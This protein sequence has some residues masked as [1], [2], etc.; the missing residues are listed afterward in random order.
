LSFPKRDIHTYGQKESQ[1]I[2]INYIES[3][4]RGTIIRKRRKRRTVNRRRRKR[5]TV[6]RMRR[7]RRTIIRKRRK[8]RERIGTNCI[9]SG[10]KN[11]W[12]TFAVRN[13][14]YF[15]GKISYKGNKE[16]KIRAYKL[17]TTGFI[18]LCI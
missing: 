5:R 4:M 17:E 2:D 8:R 6:N 12:P 15:F 1:G 18:M 9:Y 16:L 13:S 10:S 3:K 7:K 14:Y 11:Y